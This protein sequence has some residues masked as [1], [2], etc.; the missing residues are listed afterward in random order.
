MSLPKPPQ[1]STSTKPIVSTCQTLRDF[2]FK[3][4]PFNPQRNTCLLHRYV[5]YQSKKRQQIN[6]ALFM[7]K[8]QA[9]HSRRMRRA[10]P[11][12]SEVCVVKK[13]QRQVKSLGEKCN[14]AVTSFF[15]RKEKVRFCSSFR[16][17]LPLSRDFTNISS[18]YCRRGLQQLKEERR[19][20][21]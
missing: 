1:P 21:L 6:D 16:L 8:E 3:P 5:D 10:Q 13:V 9:R 18:L 4:K 7:E 14:R 11:S 19:N 15:A 17:I 12:H 20:T 2:L